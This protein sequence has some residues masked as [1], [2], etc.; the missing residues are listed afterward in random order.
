MIQYF[1]EFL[2]FV[3]LNNILFCLLLML[4]GT[5]AK[6]MFDDNTEGQTRK[7]INVVSALLI[8]VFSALEGFK[9]Y[10]IL[11]Y[12]WNT[13]AFQRAFKLLFHYIEKT[14]VMI[15]YKVIDYIDNLIDRLLKKG[16]K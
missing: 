2:R 12:V 15:I 11:H 8:V 9:W 3:G 10:V 6:F 1:N 13:F 16:K 14:Y 4:A 5:L 7:L